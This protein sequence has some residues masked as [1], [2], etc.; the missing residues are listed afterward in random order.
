M[1]ERV[2]SFTTKINGDLFTVGGQNAQEFDA[3]LTAA[4][5]GGL[6]DKA[7]ALQEVIKGSAIT[8]IAETVP[9][10]VVAEPAPQVVTAPVT[11]APQNAL[12]V[13]QDRWGNTYTYGHPEAPVL[14]DGRGRYIQKDWMNK[15]GKRSLA[16][17]DPTKGPKPAKPGIEEAPLIWVQSR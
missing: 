2:F 11:A 13:V 17:V 6:H 8:G 12:E 7:A 10:V 15:Q 4:I 9:T 1:S 3:N 16:W 14:P 5:I